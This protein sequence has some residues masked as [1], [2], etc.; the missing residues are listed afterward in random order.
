MTL[1][2]RLGVEAFGVGDASVRRFAEPWRASST[3]E[4]GACVKAVVDLV[5]GRD[6][7]FLGPREPGVD[8][9]VSA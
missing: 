9:A 5:S 3:R 4:H 7:V 8:R 1:C 6:P 2:R